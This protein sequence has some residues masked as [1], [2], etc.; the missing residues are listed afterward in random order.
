MVKVIGDDPTGP[1]VLGTSTDGTGVE[2]F[3][4]DH[5][6]VYGHSINAAG[7]WGQSLKGRAGFFSGNVEAIGHL[8]K[9]G[10]GFKI[11][12]PLDPANKYLSHSF[13][14]SPDMKNL[15]DGVAILD[16]QGENI[17]E[18]PHWFEALNQEFRYQQIQHQV[19]EEQESAEEE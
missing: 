5:T 3:S 15:Y 11:D 8:I 6:G 19:A 16:A 9:I 12:H 7:V 17:V 2:G 4:P 13:V 10:G 18:L 14:E 1:G